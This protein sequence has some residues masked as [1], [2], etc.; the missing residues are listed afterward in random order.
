MYCQ[1]KSNNLINR[2]HEKALRIA[3]NDYLS[4]FKVLL[5]K[6]NSVTIHQRNIQ[7]LTLEVYKTLNDLN[8]D[9]MKEIFYLK[10]HDYPT[11]N[12]QIVYPNPRTVSYGLETFGYKASQIWSK[13]PNEIQ[14]TDVP[15][16]KNYIS[17]QSENICNCNLCKPYIAG[18]GYI[19][20]NPTL[21][22][23]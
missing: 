7:A 9:F 3:Y 20:N 15:T 22:I 19:Q 2:I 8:P 17:K 5:E 10:Q 21:K 23:S 6:D 14:A 16:F 12:Q 13:I 1:R 11:R 18:L 4:D